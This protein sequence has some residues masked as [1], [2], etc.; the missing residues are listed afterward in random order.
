MSFACGTDAVKLTSWHRFGGN[1]PAA[2]DCVAE[3]D[4]YQRS[5]RDIER[6][7][8][9]PTDVVSG[10]GQLAARLVVDQLTDVV[11]HHASPQPDRCA[12]PTSAVQLHG[13]RRHRQRVTTTNGDLYDDDDDEVTTPSSEFTTGSDVG[14]DA[15]SLRGDVTVG[16]HNVADAVHCGVGGCRCDVDDSRL[17]DKENTQRTEPAS[18]ADGSSTPDPDGSSHAAAGAAVAG[19]GTKRRGP[20]TTIKAKQLEMLKSAFAATPKP[21]RHIREQLAHD[22]GLNMRVIQARTVHLAQSMLFALDALA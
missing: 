22:T 2:R 14:D 6:R 9:I 5:S 18:A 16:R 11:R 3:N 20:R 12:A 19:G 7:A 8:Q 21:T 13:K 10:A 4:V 15:S 1:V 17:R